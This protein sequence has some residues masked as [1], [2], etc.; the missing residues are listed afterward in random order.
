MRHWQDHAKIL[1]VHNFKIIIFI[2][3]HFAQIAKQPY[4]NAIGMHMT[5]NVW[6]YIHYTIYNTT[7]I[8]MKKTYS[9]HQKMDGV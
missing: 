2:N 5:S 4:L 8:T 3:Y 6:L 9:L 1:E 7:P